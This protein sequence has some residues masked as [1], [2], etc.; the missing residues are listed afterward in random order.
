MEKT[1]G[2]LAQV[3]WASLY[4]LLNFCKE[5]TLAFTE[6]VELLYQLLGHYTLP[7]MQAARECI[8]EVVQRVITVLYLLNV[9]FLAK[10][11]IN[12]SVSSRGIAAMLLQHH[13]DKPQTWIPMVI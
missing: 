9:D 4:G 10:L 12:A 2:E 1:D 13:P 8:H 7:W 5:Y 6:V 3:V 11:G